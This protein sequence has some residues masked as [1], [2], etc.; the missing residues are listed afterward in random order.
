MGLDKKK[1]NIPLEILIVD[2]DFCGRRYLQRMLE[3]YGECDIAVNGKEAIEAYEQ[4]LKEEFAYDLICLDLLMPVMDG[5]ET[6][7]R[8]RALEDARGIYGK[9]CVKVII[10]SALD[11]KK[12]MLSAYSKGCESYITKPVDKKKL[13]QTLNELGLVHSQE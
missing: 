9:N 5:Y 8:I 11:D 2:D 10:T 12:S 7:K 13:L 3:D 4:S 1:S 6:L